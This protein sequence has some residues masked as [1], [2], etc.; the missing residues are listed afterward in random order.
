MKAVYFLIA[1]AIVMMFFMVELFGPFLKAIFVSVLLTV[2]TSTLTLYLEK[3][4]K[5]LF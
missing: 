4:L 3:K 1:I 5:K 2:A